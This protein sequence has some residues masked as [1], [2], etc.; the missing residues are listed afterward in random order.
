MSLLR[1]T[2]LSI[3]SVE[4]TCGTFTTNQK[5][6]TWFLTKLFYSNLHRRCTKY[7]FRDTHVKTKVLS[8]LGRDCE[9]TADWVLKLR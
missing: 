1:F 3:G 6:N 4:K 7:V 5:Q 8:L 2:S 9:L